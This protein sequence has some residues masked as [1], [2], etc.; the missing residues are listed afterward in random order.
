MYHKFRNVRFAAKHGTREKSI[1]VS[2]QS[3]VETL[4][5]I[6]LISSS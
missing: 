2:R 4:Q 1:E 6:E 5:C 3:D